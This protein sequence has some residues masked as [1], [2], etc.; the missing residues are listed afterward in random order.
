MPAPSDESQFRIDVSRPSARRSAGPFILDEKWDLK[1]GQHRLNACIVSGKSFKAVIVQGV[2]PSVFK[3]LDSGEKR[4]SADWLGSGDY[5]EDNA[6]GLAAALRVLWSWEQGSICSSKTTPS[7]DE[8]AHTLDQHPGIRKFNTSTFAKSVKG[9][10]GSLTMAL[11]YIFGQHDDKLADRFFTSLAT[12][13]QLKRD[14]PVLILRERLLGAKG[15]DR[16]SQTECAALTVKA[17]NAFIEGGEFTPH[18]LRFR[19]GKNGEEFPEIA[20]IDFQV[21]RK[22]IETEHSVREVFTSDNQ[23]LSEQMRT[24]TEAR[25]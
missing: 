15:K 20:G 1:N 21:G 23:E 25:S 10:P 16:L 11:R 3:K 8:I 24:S 18:H 17:W 6:K 5:S 2:S 9:M 12:G 4:R 7:N 19:T 14:N 22:L 13:E